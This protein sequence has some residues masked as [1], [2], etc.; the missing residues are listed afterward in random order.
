MTIVLLI[1]I[2]EKKENSSAVRSHRQYLLYTIQSIFKYELQENV[3][4]AILWVITAFII[5]NETV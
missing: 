4:W 3:T 1:I 5:I 2:A